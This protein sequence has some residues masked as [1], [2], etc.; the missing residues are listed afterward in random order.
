MT[1][2]TTIRTTLP[3]PLI[4]RGKVRDIYDIGGDRLLI[5]TTDRISAFDV[6]LAQPIPYKGAVL[7]QLTAWWLAQLEDITPHHLISA[8]PDEIAAE[9]PALG[10][11][12]AVWALRSM[13][14]KRTQV[15]P[16]ECVVRGYITG[17]AWN[18][19]RRSGTLAGERLPAG[20]VESQRLDPPIFSPATKA[21]TGHDENITFERMADAVGRPLAVA[22]RE[23]S[24]AVFSRGR[25]VAQR[26]DIILADSKFEFGHLPDGTLL[27][28]DEVLTPDSSRLW[29]GALYQPGRG[30]PSLDKQP[31]RDYL[32]ALVQQGGW[33]KEPPPP[34]LSEDVV[35][36]T[37]RRY[38]DVY[39]RLTGAPLAVD[40]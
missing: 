38:L 13:L 32:E 34:D 8:D 3:F 12:R 7:T 1:L 9:I 25:D 17:S 4:G 31:V 21:A 26:A 10:P 33:N 29:P 27:L 5:V 37:S 16:V 39:E 36:S 20:M 6:V 23:R 19:Y 28:I 40:E 15:V 30:Q 14:V 18:E 2:A 35:E 22:L 11:H 24:L